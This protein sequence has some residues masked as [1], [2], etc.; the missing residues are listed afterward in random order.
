MARITARALL[1]L[2]ALNADGYFALAKDP[3]VERVTGRVVAYSNFPPVCLN[4]NGYWSIL[5]RVKHHRGDQTTSAVDY[6][7]ADFSMPCDQSAEWLKRE[8]TWQTFR[9]VRLDRKGD[10]VLQQFA[11]CS[12]DSDEACLPISLWKPV[13]GEEREALPFGKHLRTYRMVNLP[14]APVL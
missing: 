13:P 7:E 14:L 8:Q 9:L 5:I 6:V 3:K 11:N 1:L 2:I 10:N 12:S 4:G